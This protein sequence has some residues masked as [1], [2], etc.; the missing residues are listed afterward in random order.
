MNQK[1]SPLKLRETFK[2]LP[3]PKMRKFTIGVG[4]IFSS[5]SFSLKRHAT[6]SGITF[7]LIFGQL[8]HKVTVLYHFDHFKVPIEVNAGL[9]RPISFKRDN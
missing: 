5:E 6:I 7:S 1:H 3:N 2:Q 9:P 8:Q 4:T